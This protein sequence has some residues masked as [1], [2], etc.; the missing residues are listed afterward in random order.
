MIICIVKYWEDFMIVAR[1]EG[2]LPYD[3]DCKA[4]SEYFQSK[5]YWKDVLEDEEKKKK[6]RKA[7]E[8]AKKKTEEQERPLF[9]GYFFGGA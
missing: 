2:H 7:I 8:R 4:E 6:R 3:P 1:G 5:D 9:V